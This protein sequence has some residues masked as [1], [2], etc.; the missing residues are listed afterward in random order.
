MACQLPGGLA[1]RHPFL[2]AVFWLQGLWHV[3]VQLSVQVRGQA[4]WH[5]FLLCRLGHGVRVHSLPAV[6]VPGH[7]WLPRQSLVCLLWCSRSV[8]W[9][10]SLLPSF[11]SCLFLLAGHG[12][13][14]VPVSGLGHGSGSRLL[15]FS[16]IYNMIEN[17]KNAC[18]CIFNAL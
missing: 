6:P 1:V 9:W 7:R 5:L 10:G 11:L 3:F 13:A 4:W 16:S 15:I 14:R 12:R 2:C 17:H 18:K 8:L